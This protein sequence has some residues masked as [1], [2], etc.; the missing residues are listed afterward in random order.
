MVSFR[1]A[2]S[3]RGSRP[4]RPMDWEYVNVLGA[5]LA[6]NAKTSVQVVSSTELNAEYT[7]PTLM[8]ALMVCAARSASDNTNS[9]GVVAFGLIAWD[10]IN[11]TPPVTTECPGPITNG[12]L[13]WILRTALPF[14]G[15]VGSI[16][17]VN[18]DGQ[19]RSKAR[20]RLGSSRTVLLV[21][22]ALGLAVTSF[23]A[24]VRVLIKE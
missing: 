13:D 21:V 8:G 7:D 2:A 16:T 9:A 10:D 20:R 22:E 6:A 24:D 12:N 23:T 18:L 14:N 3:S 4:R 11:N 19:F 5:G 15:P 17:S 1:R